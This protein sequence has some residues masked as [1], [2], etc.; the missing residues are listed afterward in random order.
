[1]K[2][3]NNTI[4]LGTDQPVIAIHTGDFRPEPD[5]SH[6]DQHAPEPDELPLTDFERN[7][8]RLYNM[9]DQAGLS[10]ILA[11][12]ENNYKGERE[13]IYQSGYNAGYEAGKSAMENQYRE[14]VTALKDVMTGLA[15]SRWRL[16][17]EAEL[18][19]IELVLRISRRVINSEL[20]NDKTKIENVIRE[21]I[22]QI[23]QDEVLEILL[24]PDDHEYII[25]Q[26]AILEELPNE[27]KVKKVTTMN[28]GGCIVNTNME[29]IDATVETKLEQIAGSLYAN[30]PGDEE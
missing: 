23:E 12:L 15:E 28:R 24:N 16:E 5:S 14:D 18:N 29:S 13:N 4:S 8:D 27:V 11:Q 2:L 10:D 9:E 7:M 6:A 22:H 30:L 25:Y 17:K 26:S 1:M 21:T 20:H 19:L 3:S